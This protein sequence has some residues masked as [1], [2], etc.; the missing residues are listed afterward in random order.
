M[1]GNDETGVWLYAVT[2]ANAPRLLDGL[3]GVT[4]EAPRVIEAGALAAVAGDV[5]LSSFGE[6]ALR[7]NL[8]DLDWLATVAR[9]HDTLIATLVDRGPW[10]RSASRRCTTTTL[11]CGRRSRSGPTTSSARSSTSRDASN[12]A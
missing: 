6:E 9:A 1:T 11:R 7:H 10:C 8:E 12:G 4:A 2:R 3:S 5:P